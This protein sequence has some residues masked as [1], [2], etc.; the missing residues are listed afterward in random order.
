MHGVECYQLHPAHTIA[1]I[2][3]VP[4]DKSMTHRALMLSAL[5]AGRSV[6]TGCLLAEDTLATLHALIAM[7]VAVDQQVENQTITVDG[8]GLH[9]LAPPEA[10]LDLANAGTAM[11]LFAGLLAGQAFGVTLVGDASLMRR[12]MQRVVDPLRAMGAAISAHN[13]CAPLRLQ[14]VDAIQ[15]ITYDLP[16][17]SAQLKSAIL[18]AAM[19]AS[20][21][22][23]VREPTATRD[24]TE[25]MLRAFGYPLNQHTQQISLQGGHTLVPAHIDIP[26]DFSSAA[27]LMVA[28]LLVPG[29][30]LLLKNVGINP[31]RTALVDILESMGARIS[32]RPV[33]SSAFE[34]VADIR[35]F[36]S[37]LH[38]VDVPQDRVANAIDELPILMI[39]AAAARGRT[40][41][42]GAKELR[43]K[44]SDRIHTM[45]S[46][47]KALGISVIEHPDGVE[48]DGG[49]FSGG[50]VESF[51][52]HRVAMAFT[53]AACVANGPVVI[54]D[55]AC[56]ATSF[57]Q[58]K[59][60]TDS[61]GFCYQ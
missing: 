55:V 49:S 18:F 27:F 44:E 4:G 37:V 40:V 12:P 51:G 23:V 42:S 31:T 20:G 41:I 34:P 25:R 10:P 47:L 50:V 5:A 59:K 2:C 8:V 57:P 17:A 24:H 35:V 38:G 1:G 22:T 52:D 32:M 53:V 60:L 15:P 7:G 61:I 36:S 43:V 26:G 21:T 9:G 19:Y 16:V 6:L 58:F 46:G 29:A 28:A 54:N 39:A 48:I 45:V 56:I 14:A 11:R 3:S 33:E 13:G 30:E